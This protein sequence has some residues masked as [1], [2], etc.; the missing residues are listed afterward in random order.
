M[1]NTFTITVNPQPCTSLSLTSPT[2]LTSGTSGQAYT[3]QLQTSGGESP[4]A[5]SLTSG[6]LP[7]GLSLSSTGLISGTPTT[8]G[9]SSFQIQATDSCPSGAQSAQNTF[10]ITVNPQPCTSLSLTSPTSLTSGT[11]GQ[12]YTYQLQTSGGQSP[13]AYS[14]TSGSLPAGLSLSS[15]G[16]ISGTPTAAGNSSFQIQATDSCPSG[17]QSVQNTFTITVNPQPSGTVSVTPIPSSINIPRGQGSSAVVNYQFTGNTT[18]NTTLTSSSGMYMVGNNTIEVTSTPLSVTIQNGYGTVSETI[19][20]PV[21]VIERALQLGSNKVAFVRTFSSTNLSVTATESLNITTVAGADFDIRRIELYFGNRRGEI[22]VDQFYPDLQAY[23]D[24]RFVGTGLLQGFWEV[25]G[26]MLNTVSQHL[27]F[28]GSVTLKTPEIPTLSTFEPGTHIVRFVITNPVTE[29]TLPSILY[30]V[31]PTEA[32]GKPIGIKLSGPDNN[33]EIE[34][35][36]VKFD[37][38]V[39]SHAA[40]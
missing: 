1:Q 17:A 5:Y 14:L 2:S 36:P 29:L 22:T 26:T 32:R 24:V 34:Y 39:K 35:L 13:I 7:A 28:G 27:T 12:A 23:A 37:G 15:T 4:I 38:L 6:S 10:T 21:A 8:A 11:S 40:N 9:I 19:I 20:I 16:L 33:S 25:D 31:T 3:Y 18:L 30:Y